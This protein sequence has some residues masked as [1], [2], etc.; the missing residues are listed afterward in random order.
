MSSAQRI[1]ILLF[2]FLTFSIA[3]FADPLT[4][5]RAIQL[6]L[7][8]SPTLAI[9]TNDQVKAYESYLETRNGYLPTLYFGSGLAKT[10]GFPLSIEG[11]APSIFN[12]NYQS[13]LVNFAQRDYIRSAKSSWNAANRNRE[14]LRRD[15]I[16]DVASTYIE[17]EKVS[18]QISSADAQRTEANKLV[19]I[20][21]QRVQAGLATQLD[22]TRARLVAARLTMKM[23]N[24]N[25]VADSLK[26]K[27]AQETGL[28]ARSIETVAESIP[29][30]PETEQAT[31]LSTKAVSNS[32][33]IA[34]AQ[35]RATAAAFLARGEH[36][37]F[38]PEIDLVATYGL[39]SKYNNYDLYFNHFQ[40]NNAA[41]GVN[42]RVPFLNYVA[43]AHAAQADAEALK[44]KKQVE[45]TRNQVSAETLRLQHQVAQLA[46]AQ[47]VAQLEWELADGQARAVRVKTETAGG[48][49]STG[50]ASPQGVSL[51]ASPGD[52]VSAELEAREKYSSYLD[53]SF[54][55]DK[56][57]LQL[58]RQT[59][60]LESW[61]L[62][63]K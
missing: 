37:S 30:L 46:A 47:Q 59:G 35:D 48:T 4:F 11:S 18:N 27:L 63:K 50:V 28:P 39:F 25:G 60:E 31:D 61:A 45:I 22:F 5:E 40:Q 52:L 41:V 26:D 36:K 19:T 8:H 2:A 9:A 56:A 1:L 16:L 54:E 15:V 49:G 34:I 44:A 3:S 42:I 38:L 6:A 10:W 58:L 32:G 12:V 33:A 53:T 17:L 13:Y 62:P 21:N 7:T 43:R 55:Y 23:A 57:R 24:L 14:D 29:K 51:T 20:V